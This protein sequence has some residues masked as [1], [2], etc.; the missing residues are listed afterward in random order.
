M[1]LKSEKKTKIEVY[2]FLVEMIDQPVNDDFGHAFGQSFH[3]TL[4]FFARF[5]LRYTTDEKPTII[6]RFHHA[7]VVSWSQ[8]V[9]IHQLDCSISIMSVSVLDKRKAAV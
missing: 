5:V 9:V 6:N 7:N 2:P 4:D 8:F 3:F 1:E